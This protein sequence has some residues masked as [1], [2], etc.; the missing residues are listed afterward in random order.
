LKKIF[1]PCE[2]KSLRTTLHIAHCGFSAEIGVSG[3]LGNKI[4]ELK[5]NS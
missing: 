3:F 1:N 2:N 5:N 4:I